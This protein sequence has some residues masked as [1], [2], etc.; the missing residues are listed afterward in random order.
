MN[1]LTYGL[2]IGLYLCVLAAAS[3]SAQDRDTSYLL[4]GVEIKSLKANFTKTNY[5]NE[6]YTA[7]ALQFQLADLYIKNYGV[8]QLSTFSVRGLGP[9]NVA[10]LWEGLP[11][12]S[13]MNGLLDLNQVPNSLLQSIQYR[14]D[15]NRLT[16]G[17]SLSIRITEMNENMVAF[18]ST[19][20]LSELFSHKI[21]GNFQKGKSKFGFVNQLTH[22]RNMFDYRD[23]SDVRRRLDHNAVQQINTQLFYTYRLAKWD[24]NTGFWYQNQDRRIPESDFYP[25]QT[26]S[27]I[28][29]NARVFA[30]VSNANWDIKLSYMSES[31]Q[32]NDQN[33][34]WGPPTESRHKVVSWKGLIQYQGKLNEKIQFNYNLYPSHYNVKSSSLQDSSTN[35]LEAIQTANLKYAVN[36]KLSLEGGLKSQMNTNFNNLFLPYAA[37]HYKL[38]QRWMTSLIADINERNP[39]MNDLYFQFYGNINLRPETNYQIRNSWKYSN[40]NAFDK[41][42]VGIEPYYIRS[43]DKINY[44]PDSA[45]R[46]FNIDKTT[47]YGFNTNL[48]WVRK[49]SLKNSLRTILNVN[50]QESKDQNEKHLAYVPNFKTILSLNWINKYYEVLMQNNYTA[51]RF[52]NTANSG[53]LAPYLMTN[54]KATYKHIVKSNQVNFSIGID[55]LWNENFQEIQGAFMP[56]RNYYFNVTAL[57]K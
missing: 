1:K 31:Q 16:S 37:L 21:D 17:G 54:L 19:S 29:R 26:Q 7:N 32:Y 10:I 5:L 13:P 23:A 42:I 30:G 3:L 15:D 12:N 41:I 47:T 57:L 4:K 2:R 38:N 51:Q 11:I 53:S 9:E 40:G 34:A 39:T 56:L 43:I 49:I 27:L 8:G 22:G 33:T 28:D 20:Y 18:S 44:L 52:T 24:I 48:E 45:F 50:Y 46:V 25:V 35:I 6:V 36:D 14:A 55:N